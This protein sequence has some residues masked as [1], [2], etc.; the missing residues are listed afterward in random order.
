MAE[1]YRGKAVFRVDASIAIGSGHV[2]RCLTLADEFRTRGYRCQFVCREHP[3]HLNEVIG[4]RGYPVSALPLVPNADGDTDAYGIS[5]PPHADWLGASWQN[6]LEATRPFLGDTDVDW[7]VVDHYALDYRWEAGMRNWCRRILVIDDLADRAHHCDFL[8]D[9]NFAGGWRGRYHNLIPDAAVALLGPDYALLH[10]QYSALRDRAPEREGRV[11]R[12]LIYFGG[13][14][15]SNLTGLAVLAVSSI[16]QS[17]IK[18]DVVINP[19]GIHTESVR[20]MVGALPN[21]RLH[22]RLPNLASLMLAADL[23]IGAA[24]ASSWERC[25]LG[26]PS[27][28]I[29]IADNQRPIAADLANRGI[30]LWVGHV[31]EVDQSALVT[32]IRPYLENGLSSEWSR[33]CFAYVDGGGTRR[34]AET[35]LLDQADLCVRVRSASVSDA[36]SAARLLVGASDQAV[37]D[38]RRDFC[39]EL[40]R[41]DSSEMFVVEPS[42]HLFLGLLRFDRREGYRELSALIDPVARGLSAR[43]LTAGIVALRRSID[44][45]LP[46]ALKSFESAKHTK[47]VSAPLSISICSDASSWINDTA[48]SLIRDWVAAGHDLCWAHDAEALPGGDICFF[49]SYGKIVGAEILARYKNCLVVHASE[50]PK[51]RGW[52]PASWLIL[53]GEHRIPVTLFEAVDQVDAGKIYLQE[54]I[55]LIGTELVEDWRNLLAEATAHLTEKFVASYPEV[56]STARAQSGQTT[57]YRRRRAEDSRL[58]VDQS[59]GEQFRLLQ[60]VDNDS[61]PAFFEWMGQEYVLHVLPKPQGR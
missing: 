6:D 4:G 1:R 44:C 55:T 28:V 61:Y 32:A 58:S 17:D 14:D 29:S 26:L 39:R 12:V 7:L 9:Q 45:R 36:S 40:R 10:P 60:I 19:D 57:F 51:G 11:G 18:L 43:C 3:G 48:A 54:W 33:K 38:K 24:G 27:V 46:V 21:A 15:A 35:I 49:L 20:R 50:L 59:L 13:A 41:I 34:V 2:I 30:I 31:G 5:L 47:R 42:K 52:S 16:V 37:D 25:C 53:E 22:E 8:L 23:A 56:L